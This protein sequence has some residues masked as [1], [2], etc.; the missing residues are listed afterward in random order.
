VEK[1]LISTFSSAGISPLDL[2]PLYK[3]VPVAGLL[4]ASSLY[5]S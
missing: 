1:A 5:H 2:A 4:W 3:N